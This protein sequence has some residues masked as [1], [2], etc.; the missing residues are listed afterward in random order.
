TRSTHASSPSSNRGSR[1][2]SRARLNFSLTSASER[3][4]GRRPSWHDASSDHA[5]P[6]LHCARLPN[7]FARA[8]SERAVTATSCQGARGREE[9]GAKGEPDVREL[10]W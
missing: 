9:G 6:R 8:A 2:L 10:I 3:T 5:V 4:A 7:R 1:T